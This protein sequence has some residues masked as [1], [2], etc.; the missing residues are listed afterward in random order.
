MRMHCRNPLAGEF[1][2]PSGWARKTGST[3]FNIT[4][5]Q[6]LDNKTFI[7]G[8]PQPPKMTYP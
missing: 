8:F 7:F 2:R 1:N 5:F 4:F 3:Q 6:H